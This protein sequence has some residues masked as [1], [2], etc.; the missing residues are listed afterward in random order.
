MPKSCEVSRYMDC[1]ERSSCA[2]LEPE[3]S[4]DMEIGVRVRISC[5]T[6]L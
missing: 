2:L 4:D 5:F 6:W 3:T 1:E